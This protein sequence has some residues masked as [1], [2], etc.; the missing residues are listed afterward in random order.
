[1]N[2]NSKLGQGSDDIGG[3]GSLPGLKAVRD[4]LAERIAVL[5]AEQARRNAGAEIRRPAWKNLVF[6]GGPG[7]G[8]SRAAVAVARGYRD[9]G[10]LPLGH[11]AEVAAADL[12]AAE[13]RE[14]ARL[15]DEAAGLVPGGVLVITDAH[16]WYHLPDHGRQMLRCLYQLL[17]QV[18]DRV[19]EDLAVILA[20]RAGSLGELLRANPA[21]A[22]RFP[23]V[24]DFP[25]YTAYELASVFTALAEEAGF[26]LAPAVADKAATV[27]GKAE[28]RLQSGNARLAVRLLDQATTSQARRIAALSAPDLATLSTIC[29]NDIPQHIQLDRPI[30]DDEQPG[31]SSL[32]KPARDGRSAAVPSHSRDR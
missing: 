25:G 7:T 32:S 6:T 31:R 30:T 10:L 21:L 2:G 15:V 22:A 26:R 11:A 28:R 1:V 18:R 20:G 8:K 12:I 24:I 29:P 9:L 23:A 17:T 5:Q 19:R 16:A 4:Q 13:P 27:L 3:L 14:A